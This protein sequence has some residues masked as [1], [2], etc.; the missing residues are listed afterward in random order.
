MATIGASLFD[1]QGR[2]CQDAVGED[3][4]GNKYVLRVNSSG[5]LE[6]SVMGIP[7][8]V[9]EVQVID[10]VLGAYTAGDVVGVDDCCTTTA[11]AWEWDVARVAGGYVLLTNVELFNDTENQAV[12]YDVILFNADPTGEHRDN[13]PNDNPLKA[14]RLKYLCTINLPYSVARGATVATHTSASPST[15]GGLPKI[16]K[17][18]AGSTKI[19][20]ILVTRTAYTQTV[21]ADE[22]EITLSGECY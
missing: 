9:K 16:V 21:S 2:P 5:Q 18:A 1:S 11:L 14:D 8:S 13:F 3:S 20:G 10:A 6:A 12:Q 7:F 17:C 22:I 4:S 19:Y 15:T